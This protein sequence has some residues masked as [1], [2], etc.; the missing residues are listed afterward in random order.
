[1]YKKI[2]KLTSSNLTDQ[3]VAFTSGT[4]FD[5]IAS[6]GFQVIYCQSSKKLRKAF[7]FCHKLHTTFDGMV[8]CEIMKRFPITLH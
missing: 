2:L 1:M 8:S 7:S 3:Q 4:T 5:N 6:K